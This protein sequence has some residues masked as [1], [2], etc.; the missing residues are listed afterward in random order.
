MSGSGRNQP[1][2]ST[3]LVSQLTKKCQKMPGL[4]V[5]EGGMN[6][7]ISLI[8]VLSRIHWRSVAL[9]EAAR[10]ERKLGGHRKCSI[11]RQCP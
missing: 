3:Q 7:A 5:R 9:K 11:D 6:G 4:P 8:S 2:P 10:S 1:L